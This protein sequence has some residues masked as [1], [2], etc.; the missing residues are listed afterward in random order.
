M[1]NNTLILFVLSYFVFITEAESQTWKWAVGFGGKETERIWDIK[2][3]KSGN[4]F[5]TGEFSD[6][7]EIGNKKFPSEG[8]SDLFLAKFD[9]E[10][11][12][13]WMKTY[14][15]HN[16]DI[17]IAIGTD[18]HENCYFTGFF[19]DTLKISDTSL[20]AMGGWDLFLIKTDSSGKYQWARQIKGTA[21]EVGYGISVTSNGFAYITGWYQ[22]SV[23][24][25]NGS[26]LHNFG[27][28]DILLAK[29]SP[30][31][32]L[33][34]ASHAGT[35][36]VEYGYKIDTDNAGNCFLT[37]I[38]GE[39]NC[40]FGGFILHEAGMFVAKY[41]SNGSIHWAI[42]G[43]DASVNDIS[44]DINGDGIAT[45]R[46]FGTVKFGRFSLNSYNNTNDAYIARFS[47]DGE[48]LWAQSIGRNGDDKGR[49][50]EISI[51]SNG[52]TGLTYDSTL[53][54]N[55]ITYLP[56]GNSDILIQTVT[57]DGNYGWGLSAGGKHDDVVTDIAVD[58]SGNLIIAGWY[59][60]SCYFGNNLTVSHGPADMNCFIS[61]ISD[62]SFNIP[63]N[64]QPDGLIVYPN[65]A[66]DKIFIKFNQNF[67]NSSAYSIFN[68]YGVLVR[69]G[70]LSYSMCDE[71]KSIDLSELKAGLYLLMIKNDRGT[72]YQKLII[73]GK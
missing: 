30:G 11:N 49:C 21:G 37:G 25:H 19:T 24:F 2:A 32:D 51:Y 69:K 23:I 70:I 39:P 40:N 8:L 46:F 66:N 13:V 47:K 60:D 50:S 10:G 56:I 48:W 61:K 73:D 52:F 18:Q 12:L 41:Y 64:T 42:A 1:K 63:A 34:W 35:Y 20:I 55:N 45:G 16:E 38:A 26:V 9:P 67:N 71:I 62:I 15:S 6:T 27:S 5:I 43:E 36:G 44:V 72:L 54:V 4:I 33:L 29:Y 28:S 31:G 65:P 22:D 14:G 53:I 68:S 17:A 57:P 58:S 3:G 7:L 59:S